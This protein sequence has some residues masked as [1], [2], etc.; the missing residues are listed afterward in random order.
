ML[1]HIIIDSVSDSTSW[2]TRHTLLDWLKCDFPKMSSLIVD[3]ELGMLCCQKRALIGD[4]VRNCP[5]QL[6]FFLF[7]IF[8]SSPR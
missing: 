6:K 1:A 3:L 5:D 4:I 7:F 8:D 2:S